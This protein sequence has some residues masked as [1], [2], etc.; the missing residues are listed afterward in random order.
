MVAEPDWI[1]EI[2]RSDPIDVIVSQF[3]LWQVSSARNVCKSSAKSMPSFDKM[4][5]KI[6]KE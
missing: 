6:Q 3:D 2:R 1:R 5:F 4:R